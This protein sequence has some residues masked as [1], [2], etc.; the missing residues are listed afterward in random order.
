[1]S[2]VEF[3]RRPFGNLITQDFFD[4]DD[5]FDSRA[6]VRDM[7]PYRFWNGKEPNEP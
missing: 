2:L 7:M 6:W 5:F 4:M 3:N 1:M